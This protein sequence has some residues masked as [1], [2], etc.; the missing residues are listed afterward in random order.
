MTNIPLAYG[1][2]CV[3]AVLA[4]RLLPRRP[5]RHRTWAWMFIRG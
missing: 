2:V 5:H 4:S 1:A 3:V